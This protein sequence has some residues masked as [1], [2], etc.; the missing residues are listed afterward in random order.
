MRPPT[1]RARGGSLVEALVALAVLA[2]GVATTVR[3]QGELRLGAEVARQHAEAVRL[4]Q[5]AIEA[6][7]SYS[8]IA[9]AEGRTT[10]AGLDTTAPTAIA[11]DAQHTVFTLARTVGDHAASPTSPRL[12]TLAVDVTWADRR[13]EP[14]AVGLRTAIA[15]MPPELSGLL[16]VAG[17]GPRPRLAGG[18][19]PAIPL[20]AVDTGTTSR[21]VPPPADAAATDDTVEWIFDNR[22]G[23]IT[24]HCTSSGECTAT[25]A[26]LLSGHVRFAT[27]AEP[28]TPAQAELPPGPLG[29]TAE[30]IDAVRV[31]VERTAPV[32]DRVACRVQRCGDHLRDFCAL[33]VAGDADA[34][35][36]WSGRSLVAALPLAAHTLDAR[37]DAFRVRRYTRERRHAEVPAMV[38]HDHP[39]DYAGVTEPL[40]QH[41]FL[42]VRAGDGVQPFDCPDDDPATV[43]VDGRT[44]HHQPSG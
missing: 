28:P 43:G 11:G 35:P 7:R 19:H 3:L 18:R 21:F 13:G 1:R 41:N 30:Q 22:S 23:L 8:A 5:E 26:W 38:N 15:A 20:E 32:A 39:L 33:P 42:V 2:L 37:A 27:A 44:W 14:H 34:V 4:A 40:G 29:M 17:T 10:Y 31:V 6:S 25:A 12:K 36:R 9:P 16:A 24:S